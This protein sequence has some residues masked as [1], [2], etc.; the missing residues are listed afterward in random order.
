MDSQTFLDNF[1]IIAE[2]PGGVDRLRELILNLAFS[3]QL[4][5]QQSDDSPVDVEWSEAA[6]K[7]DKQKLWGQE[8]ITDVPDSWR[9][10]P[11]ARLGKWGSGGTPTRNNKAYYGGNIPWLVIGDL[12]DGLVTSAETHITVKG[13]SESSATLVPVGAVLIA[14]YG[15]IGKSGVTGFECATNQAIAHCIP[16]TSIVSTEFLFRLI[17]GLRPRLFAQGR[18]MAQQNISQTILK[19][20]MIALPPK[21][22]QGRIVQKVDELMNLCDKL[23]A[24]KNSRDSLQELLAKAI[25][26]TLLA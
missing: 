25:T 8:F 12:N 16:D 11:L 10:L 14:M 26:S 17:H 24:A 1:G 5:P 3:A 22:E 6:L 4:V 13:L 15:S 21:E 20:L 19:H 9:V 2:A 23:E 7:L 18:G